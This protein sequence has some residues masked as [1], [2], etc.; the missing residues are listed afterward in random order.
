MSASALIPRL[1]TIAEVAEVTRM[2]QYWLREQCR[3]A[4][5]AHHRLGRCYRFSEDDLTQLLSGSRVQPR[6]RTLTPTRHLR[7]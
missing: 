3:D 5:L 7:G 6:E 4:K 2:S 1:Y